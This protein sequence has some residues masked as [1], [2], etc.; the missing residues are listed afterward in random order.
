MVRLPEYRQRVF[1][2][3]IAIE[4][5]TY[6][7]ALS[8]QKESE[9]VELNVQINLV[10]FLVIIPPKIAIS[11]HVGMIKIRTAIRV[12]N[13][14]KKLKSRP[15]WGNRLWACGYCVDTAGLDSDM[16]RK[17]VKRQEQKEKR[18][19]QKELFGNET[20][21][22]LPFPLQRARR[23]SPSRGNSKSGPLV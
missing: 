18:P 14:F 11:D 17:F 22:Q 3:Q 8:E 21:G 7:K 9:S 15:C 5:E 23:T 4:V 13:R 1:D 12:I 19:E 10:H 2:G 6:I 16:I 20:T